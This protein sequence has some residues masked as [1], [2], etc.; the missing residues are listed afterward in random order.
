M[1]PLIGIPCRAG[2]RGSDPD[3]PVYYSN[4]S[5]VHA[6]ENAGGV[7]VLIPIM[8]DFDSLHALVARLDG[9][10][11]SGGIDLHPSSYQEEVQATLTETDP[12]LDTLEIVLARWAYQEDVPTLGICRG[13]QLLNVALG[14]TL[15]QDLA[16]SYQSDLQHAN[17]TLPRNQLI[18]SVSITPDSHVHQVLGVDS[19]MVN[20]IHH[21]AVKKL[22]EGIVVSGVA[23]DGMI[24]FIEV[25]ERSFMLAIQSHPEELYHE[26]PIWTRLFRSF[27][28]ACSQQMG[29][30]LEIV[31]SELSA[32]A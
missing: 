22:G 24:E 5:Y 15:Y 20:S 10:L 2:V 16:T 31:T 12:D 13:M 19:V 30:Q 4:K 23:D 27:V 9:L 14:G 3:R 21:Q 8:K 17:G 6:V 11:L 32:S 18:H 28:G 25:P 26:Y 1:R 7:P 29:Q